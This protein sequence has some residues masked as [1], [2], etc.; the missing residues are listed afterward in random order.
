MYLPVGLISGGTKRENM[1]VED[2]AFQ[3][4]PVSSSL[5]K[6]SARRYKTPT[7]FRKGREKDF[8]FYFLE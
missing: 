6:S 7:L 1:L 4:V 5:Q 3:A 8:Y 2:V